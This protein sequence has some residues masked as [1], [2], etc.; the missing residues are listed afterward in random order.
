MRKK[1]IYRYGKVNICNI[2]CFCLIRARYFLSL[3]TNDE[4]IKVHAKML[5]ITVIFMYIVWHQI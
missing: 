4:R 3:H 2:Q 5:L 1:A